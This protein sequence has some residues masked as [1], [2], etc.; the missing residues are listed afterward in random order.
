MNDV[1]IT[2]VCNSTYES[3]E[4][5]CKEHLPHATPFKNWADVLSLPDLDVVWI[6]THPNMHAPVTISALEAGKHVFCQARMAMNL[7]EAKEMLA[8]S[9][10]HPAKVTMLCPP[11]MGMRGDRVMKRLL[12][13]NAI[14]EIYHVRLRSMNGLW[15]NPNAPAH[16]RQRQ[17]MSGLNVM[18]LGIYAEVLQRWLGPIVQVT[19]QG[20]VVI[21]ER[22][23]YTVVIPDYLAVI[24]EFHS[25]VAGVMEFS[26]VAKFGQ[27]DRLELYGSEGKL[28]Y[29]FSVEEILI[30]KGDDPELHPVEI[31]PDMEVSWTVER[32]FI[33]AVKDPAAPRPRPNFEDGVEYMRVVQAVAESMDNQCAVATR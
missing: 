24:A 12:A 32:D 26:G 25:G 30:A 16:W 15:I 3:S 6:G 33:R 29:D 1:E 28:V 10:A 19:A 31:A 7:S 27:G 23:G 13:E 17:E 21:P 2:A 14:G 8:V 11:P 4:R 5:F 22:E 20:R 9:K 18:T